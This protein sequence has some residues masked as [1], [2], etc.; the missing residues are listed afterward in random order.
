MAETYPDVPRRCLR[1]TPSLPQDKVKD[2]SLT[3]GAAGG[4]ALIPNLHHRAKE[5]DCLCPRGV[6]E[7]GAGAHRG[8]LDEG[9]H[10]TFKFFLAEPGSDTATHTFPTWWKLWGWCNACIIQYYLVPSSTMR[11][12]WHCARLRLTMW[13]F[14]ALVAQPCDVMSTPSCQS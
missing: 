9:R 12:L 13:H 2:P 1:M 3:K 4:S 5:G 10:F 7:L 14:S 11:V 6:V 8:S